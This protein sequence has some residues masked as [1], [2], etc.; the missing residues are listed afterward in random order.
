M[1][2]LLQGSAFVTGAAS[3]LGEHTA[4]A[5]AKHGIS[6]LAITDINLDGLN[7]VAASIQKEWPGVEVLALQLDVRKGEEVKAALS[8]IVAQFGRLDIAVNNAGVAGKSAQIHE[9]DD[10][11][12]ERVLGVNLHGVHRCQKEELG[13]MVKQEDLGPRRGRGTII[14]VSSIYGV[15]GPLSPIHVTAYSTA[16]HA[17]MGMTKADAA[18]YAGSNIRINAIC[19]GYVKTPMVNDG[20]GAENEAH[21]LHHHAQKTPLRRLGL[22][23][24]IADSI[25][26]LASPMSSFVNGFGLVADGGYSCC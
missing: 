24:E 26:F 10:S 15:I 3:G 13:I 22:P 9:L 8:Q 19:P 23:E 25:V 12:W 20:Q 4:Y 2:S 21:P 5:F 7:R 14:N 18:S 6:K 17:V 16:K 11:D 1:A